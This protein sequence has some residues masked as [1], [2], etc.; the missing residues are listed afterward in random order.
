MNEQNFPCLM[1]TATGQRFRVHGRILTIGGS[2]ECHIR[3]S[4][5]RIPQIGHLLFTGGEYRLHR[6]AAVPLLVNGRT[7]DGEVKLRHGDVLTIDKRQMIYLE[8]EQDAEAAAPASPQTLQGHVRELS[9]LIEG[10]VTLLRNRDSDVTNNLVT[11]VCRLLKCDA[12]RLVVEDPASGTRTTA[13]AYPANLGPERFSNRAIDWAT[14]KK[15]TVIMHDFDWRSGAG[16]TSNSLV[17][18]SIA[19][20]LCG[21]LAQSGKILGYLYLDRLQAG[22]PFTEDDRIFCDTLLPLFSEILAAD[23]ERRRQ[24]DTIARFQSDRIADAEGMMY[25]C[26]KMTTM[27]AAAT[28]IARTDAPILISG[29]TGTGKELITRFIHTHSQ[30]AKGPFKAINSGAIP[31][32][33]IESELFGHEKGAF[34]GASQRK[35]GLF[36]AARGGTLFLDEVG[37]LPLA[38]QVKLLRVLQESE[39]VR[40]GGTTPIAVDVRIIAATNR[41][42]AVEVAQERFRSDLY[43]RLNVL[44]IEAPPLR[45]RGS[46]I[47][48][49]AEF[50]I[51]RYC[52]RFGVPP[53]RLASDAAKRLLRYRWPG[54][55]RELENVIQKAII[56]TEGSQ[57]HSGA[58]RLGNDSEEE[59][60]QPTSTLLQARNQA[61]RLAII[62]ALGATHGNVSAASSLL[63]IDRKWLMKKMEEFGVA[64][65]TYRKER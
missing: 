39:I 36:E 15:H 31:A 46:D 32:S 25:E 4:D 34:T 35:I 43:F 38:L 16:E 40:V 33:L 45:D 55:I 6:L 63:D 52:Q 2:A 60:S 22:T 17:K 42:L 29:E 37:E 21:A 50:F 44:S 57:I 58:I 65:D 24:A 26:E 27:I 7:L 41:D 8:K 28:R 1:Q 64:A 53:K 3:L 23:R 20:V 13:A 10:V 19:S 48:M 30:R 54:N 9:E 47:V 51:L 61:E 11:A 18:N 62:A 14:E 56:A 49:L 5:C 59:I 12:A